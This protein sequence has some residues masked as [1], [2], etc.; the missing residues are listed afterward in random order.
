[1][2]K[3]CE[4][5]NKVEAR[6]YRYRQKRIYI[7]TSSNLRRSSVP[8]FIESGADLRYIQELLGHKSSK[9]REVYTHL[10]IRNLS[11]IK[12]LLDNLL[13]GGGR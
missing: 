12:N 13:R 2:M 8:H 5:G 3:L 7:K 10:S 11:V 1:M 9:T 4:R 6:K